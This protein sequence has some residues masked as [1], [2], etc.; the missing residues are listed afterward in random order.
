MLG[1]KDNAR[2]I[3]FQEWFNSMFTCSNFGKKDFF[4]TPI[5]SATPYPKNRALVRSFN[6]FDI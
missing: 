1:V 6:I 5:Y 3:D 2:I 4:Q